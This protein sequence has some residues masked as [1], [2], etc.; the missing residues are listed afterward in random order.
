M[1]IVANSRLPAWYTLKSP[2]KIDQRERVGEQ[3]HQPSSR[4][5]P[6]CRGCLR[7]SRIRDFVA[8]DV[9]PTAMPTNTA[10]QLFPPIK[11]TAAYPRANGTTKPPT[12]AMTPTRDA[13]PSSRGSISM[14][15]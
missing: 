8:S 1:A 13:L 3:R 14:P 9:T 2:A 15:M 11:R 10:S 6:A 7:S 12:A 4:A 5:R